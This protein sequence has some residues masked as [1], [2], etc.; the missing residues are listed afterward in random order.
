MR[1][2]C[3]IL[4]GGRGSRLRPLTTRR[5][6][7]AVPL[8]GKY[9]LIDIPISNCINSG[10]EDIFILTQFLSASL[11]RHIARTFVFDMFSSGR[12]EV[13]AA[14]QTGPG[15][16]DEWY[17]GTADAVRKQLHRVCRGDVRDVMI[18]S[19]DHLYRMD[20]RHLLRTHLDQHA[21]VTVSTIPVTRGDCDG[22]GVLSMDD[23]GRVRAFREK[24]GPEEDLSA[25]R[26]PEA[27]A[28]GLGD[29][30][31][32]A[33]M[34]VYVFRREVLEEVLADPD[35]ND[36][37]SQ[38]LPS[39]IST[40]TVAAHLFEDYWEDIGTIQ[41]F[42]EANL[43]LTGPDSPFRFYVPTAPIYTRPRFLPPSIIQQTHM[44]DALLSDGCLVEGALLRNS[45]V[46]VRSRIQA[47]AQLIDTVMMGADYYEDD[48]ALSANRA[49]NR[50]DIGVGPNTLIER[51]IID[52]NARIGANCV[53]RGE[54]G[55]PDE[56]HENWS[57]VDGILIIPKNAVI[58]AGTRI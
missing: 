29:R 11:N 7:P 55:L 38:I 53:L 15:S 58:P 48:A 14:E 26:V 6:K 4:G 50:L 36:F 19:G 32:L 46:G 12:V 3:V 54:Q 13:L 21:D 51:A 33:S 57:R 1:T 45:V 18:L 5:A 41:A 44:E 42:Y 47:G 52:K 56:H 2:V 22:F 16:G 10:L 37:G 35:A 9:R 25:F 8:A 34:G 24:P 27:H 49:A 40:H 31:F 43:R 20:Y 30:K 17:Q 39:M 28:A 23:G